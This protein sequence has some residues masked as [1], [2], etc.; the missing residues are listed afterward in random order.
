MIPEFAPP[1]TIM[2]SIK[3]CLGKYC[4]FTGRARRSEFWYYY[5]V[6]IIITII[7]FIMLYAIFPHIII[8]INFHNIETEG[9][10]IERLDGGHIAFLIIFFIIELVLCIPLIT[11]GIR[12]LHDIGRSGFWILIQLIPILIF[13]LLYMWSLDSQIG[14]NFYGESPKYNM[15][16]NAPIMN[17]GGLGIVQQGLY[18]NQNI[19][20]PPDYGQGIANIQPNL[21]EPDGQVGQPLNNPSLQP[22]IQENM[23]KIDDP[24][25][26]Q[27]ENTNGININD[28]LIDKPGSGN[29]NSS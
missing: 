17:D 21:Y 25:E 20:M 26:Q 14:T 18:P 4:T 3:T 5:L 24:H 12:R 9:E 6:V 27:N 22:Q 11:A 1:M 13:V 7:F 10:E 28:N 19:G 2:L 16:L 23:I 15:P 29:N 8:R